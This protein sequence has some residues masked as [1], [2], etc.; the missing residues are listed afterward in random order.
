LDQI[1]KN[2]APLT[3]DLFDD[4]E[5]IILSPWAWCLPS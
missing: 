4:R 2:L 3:P 5:Q 1:L